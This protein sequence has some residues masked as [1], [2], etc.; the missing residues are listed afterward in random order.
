STVND[1]GTNEVNDVGGK[2]SI[3]LPFDPNMHSLEDDN[4]F[5]FLRNDED[6]GRTQKG[7]SCIEGSKL[8][9]GYAGR[10][11]TIQV[12]R[13]SDLVDL[14][15]GKRTIGSKWVF[16]NKKDEKGIV[17]RNKAR[18]VAQEYTQDEGIDYD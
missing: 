15:N 9:K 18:L 16:K 5:N 17:I 12:T 4:I 3:E 6:D 1:A 14:P 11:S 13:S 2:T 8:D 10:A 7:N